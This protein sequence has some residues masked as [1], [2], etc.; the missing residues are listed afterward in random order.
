MSSG[1]VIRDWSISSRNYTLMYFY[2]SDIQGNSLNHKFSLI[3]SDTNS[4]DQHNQDYSPAKQ[5]TSD[6]NALSALAYMNHVTAMTNKAM[7]SVIDRKLTCGNNK[8]I[9]MLLLLSHRIAKYQYEYDLDEVQN[10]AQ[11]KEDPNVSPKAASSSEHMEIIVFE[12]NYGEGKIW[13]AVFHKNG[14]R[15]DLIEI[16][17]KNPGET[18]KYEFLPDYSEGELCEEIGVSLSEGKSLEYST[19]LW[20]EKQLQH[21][22]SG[23]HAR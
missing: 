16:G 20:K 15:D 4:E 10:D 5:C 3:L 17:F 14:Q 1:T 23:E 22:P 11:G 7:N 6:Q 21:L 12:N 18:W 8:T 19:A 13:S 2:G 9:P